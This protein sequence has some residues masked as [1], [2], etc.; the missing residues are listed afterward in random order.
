MDHRA[1]LDRWKTNRIGF[2]QPRPNPWLVRHWSA[3]A[4][5]GRVF[6]PLCGKSL[7]MR[8]LETLG[9]PV[10][11]IELAQLAVDAYFEEGGEAVRPVPHDGLQRYDGALTTLYC[12][13]YFELTANELEG[14]DAVF[15]RGALVALPPTARRRYCDHLLRI[16][17]SGTRMLLITIEYD[18]PLVAGPPFCVLPEEVHQHYG[19]RCHIET[20]S[21]AGT[22]EVP[23]HFAEQGVHR[24]TEAAYL[25]TKQS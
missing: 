22:D 6:V 10:V 25:L 16:V 4:A 23:P 5:A 18:Q 15:D 9:H 13:D 24:A 11:G 3:V 8:Y 20:L 2:H 7:D 1:W 14:V 21:R 19:R 12:G 17:P